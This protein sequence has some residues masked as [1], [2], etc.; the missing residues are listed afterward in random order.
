M[1]AALLAAALI[2]ATPETAPRTGEWVI[3]DVQRVIA[4]EQTRGQCFVEGRVEQVVRGRIY[5][6]GQ[7]LG[8]SVACVKGPANQLIPLQARREPAKRPPITV[9]RLRSLKRALVHLDA[10]A[11]VVDNDYYAVGPQPL[12]P[13]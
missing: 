6:Q 9:E 12:S 2:Q 3:L 11:R 7:Q 1:I 8:V 13:R 10:F 4:P 5:K